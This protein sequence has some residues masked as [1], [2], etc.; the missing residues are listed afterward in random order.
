[1]ALNLTGVTFI[2]MFT[3]REPPVSVPLPVTV[4]FNV[5]APGALQAWTTD[6]PLAAVPSPKSQVNL[7][8]LASV[9]VA[10]N[11][12]GDPLAEAY[13]PLNWLMVNVGPLSVLPL[14]GGG[15]PPTVTV[16]PRL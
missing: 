1:M 4:S 9:S 11:V 15:K 3:L 12:T 16:L 8:A 14:E 10:V 7:E 5:R 6:L 2:A 13:L